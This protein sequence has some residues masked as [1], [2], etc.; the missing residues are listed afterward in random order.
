MFMQWL[1]IVTNTQCTP[2]VG[3]TIHSPKGTGRNVDIKSGSLTIL[4]GSSPSMSSI[5]CCFSFPCSFDC[6]TNKQET[7]RIAE[8][9]TFK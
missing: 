9:C 6:C 5:K 3:V 1:L 7:P 2:A 8:K 4:D